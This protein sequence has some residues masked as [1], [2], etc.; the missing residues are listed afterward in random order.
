LG[1]DTFGFPFCIAG[2]SA[3]DEMELMG[4]SGL[5]PY[6]V[7]QSATINPAKFLGK[8]SEFGTVTIGRRA[9]LLH[10]GGKSSGEPGNHTETRRGDAPRTMAP[11][12]K[13]ATQM[14]AGL[15]ESVR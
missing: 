6:E 10:S 14:L 4:S 11:F 13:A 2:K 7:L 9:D 12:R 5:T 15:D 8:E 1:T 3:H